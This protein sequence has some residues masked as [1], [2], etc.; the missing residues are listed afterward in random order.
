MKFGYQ[1][2]WM[3]DKRS[4]MT[5]S[6]ELAY[7]VTNGIPNQLTQTLT[8]FQNDGYA[9]W[10]AAFWQ[11]Q[12]TRGRLTLQGAVRYDHAG[13]WFPEQTLGPSKYFPNKITFP[14]TKGVDSYNDI[15]PRL[16]V[17]YD[18]FGNGKTALKAS[19]GTLPR[20]RRRLDQL[21]Q[22]QPDAADPDHARPVR[23]SGRDAHLDRRQH[24]LPPGLRSQQPRSSR[25][26]AA[27]RRRLLRHR[28][29]HAVGPERA[30][31][32]LRPGSAEGLGRAS[33]G[34]GL[35]GGRSAAGPP[36]PVG[37]GVLQ[38][39][40]VP[41]L[42]RAGQH[43]GAPSATSRRTASSAPSD[44]RLPGGGGYTV[45]GPLRRRARASPARSSTP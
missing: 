13:S 19:V 11:E 38:P 10:H 40:G 12:Y 14:A 20:R 4:W 41:R 43:A 30:H 1:G 24:R 33:V 8:P 42:H 7:R 22:R 36:A 31:Q 16:G 39:P 28:V 9:G 2:T 29:Q 44:S 5:N 3:V 34:L 15:T 32:Q 27:G 6:T 21:R 26:S 37:R 45:V 25:I 18:L 17:A 35:L 23:R